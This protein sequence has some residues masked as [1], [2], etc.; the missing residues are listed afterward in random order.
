MDTH[1]LPP[2]RLWW[3]WVVALGLWLVLVGVASA[4]LWQLRSDTLAHQTRELNLLALSLSDE[5]DRGLRGADEGLQALRTELHDGRLNLSQPGAMQALRTRADLMPLVHHLW[6]VDRGGQ[7]LAASDATPAPELAAL[8]LATAQQVDSVAALSRPFADGSTH[9]MLVALGIRF[10]GAPGTPSGWILAALPANA[11]LG[12]FSAAQPGPEMRM[13][14]FRSDGVRLASAN[15]D[16]EAP[17][18]AAPLGVQRPD[19][20]TQPDRAGRKALVSLHNVPRYGV[21]V[22]VSLNLTSA[23]YPWRGAAEMAALVLALLLLTTLAAMYLVQ[24][25]ERERLQ[26]Q[27]AMHRQLARATRLES[28]GTLAGAMAHDFN[29]LLAG[30]VGFGEMARDAAP[31]GSDQERHLGKVLQAALRGKALVERTL[32]FS[33]GGALV[34]TVF[35]LEP[36]V[37]EALTLLS[38]S[39][40]PGQVLER[41]FDAPG[42][43]LRG[44]P[45]QAYEAVMN[46]CTNALQ[47]M[48]GSGLLSVHLERVHVAAPRWLSHSALE[49]GDYVALSVTDQGDGITPRAMEHLFEPFFTTRGAQ[50][51]TGLGLAVVHGVVA[52]LG[53]AI[54]VRSTPG[55]GACFSLYLPET[56]E[57]VSAAPPTRGAALQEAS[58]G[59]P[60]KAVLELMVVDDDPSL[61]ALEQE[62]LRGLGYASAGFTDPRTALQAL[63]AQ[64]QRFAAVITDEAMPQMTGTALTAA[65]HAHAPGLPVLLLSGYGGAL[66]AQRAAAAGVAR[67][68]TKPL[69]RAD[70]ARALSDLLG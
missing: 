53:G 68:L 46:L 19:A 9:D 55:Q 57:P 32:A 23:L 63:Q 50:S 35:E 20:E 49:P 36:V 39:L 41:G 29:N 52:E 26:A 1:A 59:V 13:E 65:L 30:I 22:V 21:K 34:S 12:A 47:A 25:A 42:A 17:H 6:L 44:D 4:S 16:M 7:V 27:R 51:G 15:V 64:P 8:A 3:S 66:L 10:D 18:S 70:L 45:S 14:V 48:P 58:Q 67:V 40:R 24:R 69:Q 54:D 2:S 43:R 62:L 38:V 5:V 61:V 31:R 33:R 37:E 60:Q 56:T 28:L 11:L